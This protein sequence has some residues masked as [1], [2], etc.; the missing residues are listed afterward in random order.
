MKKIILG[1]IIFLSFSTYSQNR[2]ELLDKGKEKLFLSDFLSKMTESGSITN[3]PVVVVDGKPYRY[4]DLE[5]QKLPLSKF[6]IEKIELL[7]KTVGIAIYG[8]YGEAGVLI[9]TTTKSKIFLLENED[10]SVYYLVDKIKT[11][12]QSEQIANSP[13][14]AID[15]VPFEYDKTLNTIILP[16]K[17]EE[18][19]DVT[20]LNKN[21]SPVIYGKDEIYGAIIIST[22]KK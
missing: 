3:E 17:K 15:G 8:S 22:S 14:I 10:D 1:F 12:F 9:I 19:T 7:K 16:I 13:L 6:A 21:S 2:Y 18:I 11:A 20:I 4:Q 5:N